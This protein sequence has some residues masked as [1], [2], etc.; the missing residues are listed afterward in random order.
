MPAWLRIRPRDS[1]PQGSISGRALRRFPERKVERPLRAPVLIEHAKAD[2]WSVCAH[3]DCGLDVRPIRQI[4]DAL[5]ACCPQD[6]AEDLA[7]EDGDLTRFGVNAGRLA[8]RIGASG[9][10]AGTVAAVID[11]VWTIGS[12][13]AGR[14]FMPC[15]GADRL[16][17][18]GAILALKSAASPRPV[19]VIADAPEPTLVPRLR[20]AGIEVRALVDVVKPD[21]EGVDRLILDAA[22]ISNGTARLV[23]HRQGQFAVLDGRR[24]DLAP[25]MFALFGM[26]VERS[27]Q[28][29]PV[30]R[31]REIEAQFQR[32]PR[33]IVRALRRALVLC[34]LAE[35]AVETRVETVR[36]RG[37]R[38]GL[39]PSEV[40]MED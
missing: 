20:E 15:D 19:T 17:A 39:A 23:L 29:D 35:E 36:S 31:A 2:S 6:A 22:P 26:L 32:T 4:G 27:V 13:P 11:G 34:G 8:E 40:A 3:G 33:E 9:G 37:Y 16:R 21:P 12:G 18:P 1:G 25:Q 10:L 7:L 38:L 14:V 5:R 30:L 28:R 24:L